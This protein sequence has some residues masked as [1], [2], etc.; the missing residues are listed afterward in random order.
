MVELCR[1]FC[2]NNYDFLDIYEQ[3]TLLPWMNAND[4]YFV[5]FRRRQ[6]WEFLLGTVRLQYRSIV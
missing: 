3:L 4:L 5:F 2:Y 6:K 1:I